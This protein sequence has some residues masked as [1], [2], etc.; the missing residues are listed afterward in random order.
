MFI[1][2]YELAEKEKN[3][4][5]LRFCTGILEIYEKHMINSHIIWKR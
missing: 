5:L 2:L 3:E 1:R 4:E